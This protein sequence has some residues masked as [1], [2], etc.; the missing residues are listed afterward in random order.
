MP[1]VMTGI[2]VSVMTT[3]RRTVRVDDD[4]WTAAL[5]IAAKRGEKLSSLIR[6]ALRGYVQQWGKK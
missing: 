1:T 3:T 2:K 5:A 6:D 4:L